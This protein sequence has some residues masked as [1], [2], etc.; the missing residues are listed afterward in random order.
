MS[1]QGFG[2]VLGGFLLTSAIDY[3]K[4][5]RAGLFII[6]LVST[7]AFGSL[8]IF[9]TQ[10]KYSALVFIFTFFFGVMDSAVS[11]HLSLICGFEMQDQSVEAIS[12]MFLVRP[13]FQCL[14]IIFE[15]TIDT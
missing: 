8:I 11:T 6:M 15:S 5:H 12:I 3:F 9:M 13:L 7:A 2:E 14:F 10:F 1:C 4:S